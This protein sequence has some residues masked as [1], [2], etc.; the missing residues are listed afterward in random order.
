MPS[1]HD[2]LNFR[3][4]GFYVEFG[5]FPVSNNQYLTIMFSVGMVKYITVYKWTREGLYFPSGI[6][7][8][9]KIAL[10]VPQT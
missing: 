5:G 9:P 7:G 2:Y 10:E 6:T 4:V 3:D 8:C 1:K